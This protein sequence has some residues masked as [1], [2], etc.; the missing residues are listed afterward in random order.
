MIT[1]SGMAYEFVPNSPGDTEGKLGAKVPFTD[2][3][4]VET[5]K[6]LHDGVIMPVVMDGKV[7]YTDTPRVYSLK[8][9]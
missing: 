1:V 6:K 9:I 3:V 8:S 7:G 5:A 2:E 4:D